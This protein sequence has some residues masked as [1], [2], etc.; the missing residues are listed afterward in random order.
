VATVTPDTYEPGTPSV[1]AS[2]VE[3]E[4]DADAEVAISEAK[5][6]EYEAKFNRKVNPSHR[7]LLS[8]TSEYVLASDCR[9]GNHQSLA[10]CD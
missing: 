7:S 6:A 2:P 8:F 1:N 4:G 3:T 5:D 9:S 10:V